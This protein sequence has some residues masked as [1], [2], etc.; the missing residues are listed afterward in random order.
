MKNNS[1]QHVPWDVFSWE[2]LKRLKWIN[3]S[4]NN[5]SVLPPDLFSSS[6]L[7]SLETILI[8]HNNIAELPVQLFFNPFLGKLVKID[9]SNNNIEHLP[10]LLFRFCN[11]SNLVTLY[12]SNNRIIDIPNGFF[13]ESCLT[14]LKILHLQNNRITI[15]T[16]DVFS[17]KVMSKLSNIQLYGNRVKLLDESTFSA[18]PLF[19]LG[20]N[21]NSLAT[22]P[23]TLFTSCKLSNL[24]KLDLSANKIANIPNSLF[25]DSCLSGL[26]F[27]NLGYN[28]LYALNV[29][30][31]NSR[32]MSNLLEIQLNNNKITSIHSTVFSS[33]WLVN[34]R[35]I[36]LNHNR[37]TNLSADFS[38]GTL[39]NIQN[40]YLSNNNIKVCPEDL[41]KGKL[42]K[43][44]KV[45]LRKNKFERL[46]R[47]QLQG[48]KSLL[49]IDF[50]YNQIKTI[51]SRD[52]NLSF[53]E[54]YKLSVDFSHN[55]IEKIWTPFDDIHDYKYNYIDMNFSHNQIKTIDELF[56]TFIA[57]IT[58]VVIINLSHNQL[59]EQK[60]AIHKA[61]MLF[62]TFTL[63]ISQ[64][65]IDHFEV[66]SNNRDEFRQLFS[67]GITAVNIS[68][69]NFNVKHNLTFN[70]T[71]LVYSS[72][73]VDINGN[74]DRIDSEQIANLHIFI[75]NLKY[76]YFCNCEMY[77]YLNFLNSVEFKQGLY[78]LERTPVF[79]ILPGIFESLICG[80]P[81]LLEGKSITQI[82][83]NS[84]NCLTSAC[85]SSALCQC[86]YTPVN[87]T[88]TINCTNIN[89]TDDN[90]PKIQTKN[91]SI[92]LFIGHNLVTNILPL[93]NI[94]NLTLLDISHNKLIEIFVFSATYFQ[95]IKI[96]NVASNYL[97]T[98][99]NMNYL[100]QLKNLEKLEIKGNPFKC[101]C[102]NID[103]K[104]TLLNIARIVKVSQVL[105]ATPEKHAN[106]V[107]TVLLDSEFRCP[108]LNLIL[109]VAPVLSLL[110]F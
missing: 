43:L 96:L 59:R 27:L 93:K 13:S 22:L 35:E 79:Q 81:A 67:G 107:I 65:S 63:D 110:F 76:R 29:G 61:L 85:T 71:N 40:I 6:F 60:T 101:I 51:P 5:I 68:S 72:M 102:D 1:V 11:L 23:P 34:L 4:H 57:H 42:P 25:T 36:N 10:P 44:K 73:G 38:F 84:F 12:L 82:A 109:I 62:K 78:D 86:V 89:I 77:N 46:P 56:D 8:N 32:R 58:P 15:L 31:F 88:M 94:H 26:K 83:H 99:P 87:Y 105:C 14:G 90:L 45:Y 74:K 95:N 92:E 49:R 70:V 48:L 21:N 108:V 66:N 37:L 106:R 16:G 100:K 20:L 7:S 19:S 69:L 39:K 33:K 28:N 18:N 91:M 103:L 80:A 75:D 17:S 53:C 9:V 41:F 64:N 47:F 98:L 104:K 30:L 3:L 2:S 55:L 50:S 24:D 97:T 52:L 54:K